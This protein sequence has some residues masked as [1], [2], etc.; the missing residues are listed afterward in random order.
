MM[1]IVLTTVFLSLLS[2]ITLGQLPGQNPGTVAQ[3]PP[4]PQATEATE[5]LLHH[6]LRVELDPINSGI[7]V[8]DRLTVPESYRGQEVSFRL[9]SNLTITSSSLAVRPVSTTQSGA[10]VA[11]TVAEEAPNT[12]YRVTIPARGNTPFTIEYR[13][14]INDIAEQDSPEYAQSFSQTSGIISELGVFLSRASIWVPLFDDGLLTFDMQVSFAE[15]A[16]GWSSVSQGDGRFG[17][18]GVQSGLP[19]RWR[20]P[21]PTEEIYLV[22]ADFTIYQQESDDTQILAYLRTPDSNL[23]TRYL[24]ATVRY[25]KLY[26]PLLGDYPYSKFA[27]VE[28][29]WETGYGMPSFTLLGEQVIRFPFILESSYP[30][31]ILHNWW[32]NGVY[33]DYASG[34]WS[35]GLTAYLADHLFREMDGVGHEYRKEMLARYKNYVSD[36][37]DFPL[38]RFTS[39][40]SA[41]TQAVGYGKTLMLWHMLRLQVGDEL[42]IEG[43]RRFYAEYEFKRATFTDIERLFTEVSGQDLS[44]FFYQWVQWIGAPELSVTVSEE[45]GDRAR[46]MFAQTQFGDPYLLKVPVALYYEGA[47]S[48]ELYDIDLSQKL[49]G[50]F[51]ENYSQLNAVLVDPYFDVFRTLDREETPPTVGEL[52]GASEIS[53]VLPASEREQWTTLAESF[54]AGTSYEFIF[55]DSITE[56]PTD[57]SLWILG[58]DN[59]L[60]QQV[61]ASVADYGVSAQADAVQIENNTFEYRDRSTVVVGRHPANPELAIGW[62]HIDD[63]VALPGMIEKLPHYGKYS[64]LS[65]TGAEPTIDVRSIWTSPS[66]PMRWVKPGFTGTIAWDNLPPMPAIAELPPK[67]LPET[68]QR[69]V[70][71]LT[72]NSMQGRGIRTRGLDEAALY[73]ADQFRR[74]GLQAVDGTYIQR[75]ERVYAGLGGVELSN[76]VGMIPGANRSLSAMP[77]V[78]G[79]HYDHLGVDEA[80]GRVYAGADDNASGI[81]VMLEVAANLARGFT[82]QRPILFVA[83]TGEESG[84]LGSEHFVSNPPGAFAA[85][86]IYAM[87]NLDAVGRLEGKPLQVF[88]T[89][90]AYEWPFMA[91][92]IGFTIGVPSEFPAQT[93]ASSDHVSFLNA[94]IPAIH[95]FSGT[96]LDYHQVTDSADKLDYP[97]MSS[98]ALWLEEAIVY[99]ADNTDPLRVNLA[100]ANTVQVSNNTGEREASLGTVPDFAYAGAGI[101]I[102]GVTPGGAAEAAGLQA[103]DVLLSYGG[104]AID[105]LQSYSNLIRSSAPGDEVT[106]TV[107][108]GEQ[109]L[110]FNVVLQAR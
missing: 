67:Y 9:N 21:Q 39:R 71:T 101:R 80:T 82:P 32:G 25:L 56:L 62:I 54:G 47:D 97:G 46:I 58:R 26:E 41:A 40:N 7:V 72:S 34:N 110:I 108:R 76:V 30:H 48:P 18:S 55:A 24:D 98:A 61:F 85:E 103:N 37:D 8:S 19:D 45:T 69:H 79:A 17:Q 29:F 20:M 23:A 73:I 99:L 87:V 16:R 70:T 31:E 78:I 104:E 59:P 50:F 49:E 64:Y 5:T 10:V 96:H 15:S 109:Q 38:S 6:Q 77:V 91:Q 35:E 89:E 28:N 105:S 107:Q 60:A 81:S 75:F 53:F 42:F 84:L 106:L 2:S 90:S 11:S 66:S 22:A 92:G 52:F 100:N 13:G 36:G 14:T 1:R 44:Q 51:A 43:L 95:L 65:F 57:R 74:A 27:L 12:E 102:S 86:D 83:F 68:L 63:M 88:G 33:P 4:A 93:I 94:G 3:T